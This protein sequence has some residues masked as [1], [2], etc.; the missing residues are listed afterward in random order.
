MQKLKLPEEVQLNT[1]AIEMVRAWITPDGAVGFV[2]T[3][4]PWDDPAALGIF[5]ADLLRHFVGAGSENPLDGQAM[6]ARAVQG[7]LVELGGKWRIRNLN[8]C[9]EVRGFVIYAARAHP[10]TSLG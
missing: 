3:E 6:L 7:L 4:N 8:R 1:Q 10:S 2:T 5:F 9:G